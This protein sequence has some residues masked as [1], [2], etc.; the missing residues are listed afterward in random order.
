MADVI[1]GDETGVIILTLWDEAINK[2]EE[3]GQNLMLKNGYVNIFQQ[4]LRLALGKRGSLE[5]PEEIINLDDVNRDNNRSEEI[6][7]D[8]N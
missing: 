8:N 1:I 2:I 7:E 4:H 6:H 5:E 3:V